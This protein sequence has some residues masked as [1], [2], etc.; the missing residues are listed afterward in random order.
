VTDQPTIFNHSFSRDGAARGELEQ[1][2]T[3]ADDDGLYPVAVL[4][5]SAGQRH[6][7]HFRT[8][9]RI[10]KLVHA[11]PNTGDR[12]TIAANGGISTERPDIY[13]ESGMTTRPAADWSA[14]A[15]Q[16]FRRSG[17]VEH[18]TAERPAPP[19]PG[20]PKRVLRRYTAPD[21]RHMTT[22]DPLPEAKAPQIVQDSLGH[23][24]SR[25]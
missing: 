3:S 1:V 18:L 11:Q 24:V 6:A 12:L 2:D 7:V 17:P 5:D 9:D 14:I 4:R 10:A 8:A 16:G 13:G 22:F 23:W 15:H 20:E 25:R 19:A 21:G